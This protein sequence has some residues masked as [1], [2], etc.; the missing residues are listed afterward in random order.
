MRNKVNEIV[1]H[2]DSKEK[3]KSLYE[4]N[5]RLRNWVP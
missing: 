2:A 5:M 3:F 4:K 1:V